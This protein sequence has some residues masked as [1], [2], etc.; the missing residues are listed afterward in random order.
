VRDRE[1]STSLVFV[2]LLV[3]GNGSIEKRNTKKLKKR[4]KIATAVFDKT[5]FAFAYFLTNQVYFRQHGP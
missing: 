2:H 1:I 5:V 3:T 4:T